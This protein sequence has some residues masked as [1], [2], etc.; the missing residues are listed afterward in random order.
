M[1]YTNA[2]AQPREELTDV[3]MEGAVNN[4]AFIG[5]TVFPPYP[6]DQ[7]VGHVPKIAIGTGNLMRATGKVRS[8]GSNFDRWGSAITDANLTLV[9]VGEELQ[10]PDEQNLVYGDYFSFESVY[11]KEAG[12]RLLRGIEMDA[13]AA[14]MD[15][16]AFDAVNGGV[17]YSLAN[18]ATI[19]GVADILA[20]IRRVKGRGERANTIVIPGDIYDRIRMST[21]MKSWIA[22][23][24]NPGA[25]VSEETIQASFA[26]KG[27]DNVLIADAFVNQ[28][29]DGKSDVIN[30]IWPLS[31]IWVG[32]V[33]S[34]SLEVGG[35]GRTFFWE[36][37]G[38][39]MNVTTYR[40]EPKKSNIIRGMKTTVDAITN[41]RCGTLIATQVT[42]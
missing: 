5:L 39:L 28:S 18:L 42:T 33:A 22:G 27:I 38:P 14:L 25:R 32:T 29:Q 9:Q 17:A 26:S 8:S 40:D 15:S 12:N 31:Y 24:I 16:T 34:G 21:D 41:A 23:S 2:T 30:P 3:I 20:A 35:A 36:K 1:L 11:A 7:I 13:A 4:P 19:T 10:I 6:L 37:E